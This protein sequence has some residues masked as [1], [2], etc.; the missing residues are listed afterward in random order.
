MICEDIIPV[1]NIAKVS[2]HATYEGIIPREVQ[3]KFLEVAYSCYTLKQRLK[4]SN[5][6]VAEVNGVVIGFENYSLVSDRKVELLAIYL[7]PD[8]QGKGIGTTLLEYAMEDL[9]FLKEIY[10][11]VE[12]E[13]TIGMNFYKAKGFKVIDE[14][15]D[16]FDGHILKT[17]R[18]VMNI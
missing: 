8:F 7:H 6:Y 9:K 11:N 2:W 1:Q 17:V 12:K 18:M 5:F 15:D 13:N 10:V 4:K 14:F 16:N 3:D